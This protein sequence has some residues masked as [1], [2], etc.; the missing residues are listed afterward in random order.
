VKRQQKVLAVLAAGCVLAAVLPTSAVRAQAPTPSP[1][2]GP[3]AHRIV[4]T[5]RGIV[6]A[7][8]DRIAIV[9]V[10][11]GT[12]A[13]QA[14]AQQQREA[15]V[16]GV[17]RALSGVGIAPQAIA[18]TRF[19]GPRG[20]QRP[21]RSPRGQQPTAPGVPG[22]IAVARMSLTVNT[23]ALATRVVAAATAGGMARMARVRAGLRDPSSYHAQAL[24]LAVQHAQADAAAMASAAGV[25]TPQLVQMQE[26]Q[27]GRF[28]R[29]IGRRGAGAG[30]FGPRW[31]GGQGNGRFPRMAQQGR[32]RFGG[33]RFRGRTT[34]PQTVPVAAAVRAVYTF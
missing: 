11:V 29:G 21:A 5:G 6:N 12:G 27:S 31:Q 25:P 3:G 13:T 8:P 32:P 28:R 1:T 16:Q 33:M 10:A 9:L 19:A 30:R 7:V 26:L 4:V 23:P 15:A 18:T 24:R 2:R 14:A 34:V 20:R 17:V 22:Y